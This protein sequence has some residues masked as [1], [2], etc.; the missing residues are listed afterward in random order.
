MRVV[1]VSSI[2]RGGPLSHLLQLAPSVAG[3]G[4]DVFVICAGDDVAAAF[5]RRGVEAVSLPLRH[6]LD[7]AGA[8]RGWGR[9]NVD[10][11]HT[12]DRRAGLLARPLGRARGARVV[13][14]LHGLP[15][16]IAPRLG[17]DGAPTPPDASRARLAWIVHGYL[18]IEATLS[19]LGTVVTPSQAM[20]RFLV[21]HGFPSGRLR[22]IPYGIEPRP[23][24]GRA[25]GG[26][27][28]I[29]TAA[30]L[31][32]W[33]GMDVLV[34]ACARVEMPLRLEVFGDG[35]ER[36]ALEAQAARLGVDARFHG[37]VADVPARLSGVDL[38]AL[39]SRGENLPVAVM[40]AMAAGLP[41]VATR[42]GGV[43]ELVVDG[44]TGLVVEPE[45][46]P[47]LA[48]ALESL[49]ARP[50][51]RRALGQAG[52]QRI[53]TYFSSEGVARRM[54]G[55]YEELCGGPRSRG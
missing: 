50:E 48:R 18:R 33:K 17:R 2:P 19:R 40:E 12:H 42:V 41:V 39:P 29:G 20:L 6:K 24:A 53:E 43:P 26:A 30:N 47:A 21:D 16:E 46:A 44:E 25:E 10:V 1:Y 9:L 31:E 35:T 5:R 34:D 51:R 36:P 49:A 22:L 32:H 7:V 4:A 11:V 14:T 55:L 54:V 15:E 23:P 52:A 38:F 13:H 27:L 37:Y 45:D 8:L 28:V 3:L